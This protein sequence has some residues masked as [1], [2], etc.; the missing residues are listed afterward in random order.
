MGSDPTL[1]PARAARQRWALLERVSK[2][3]TILSI[4]L[5]ATI[6]LAVAPEAGL[7]VRLLAGGAFLAAWIWC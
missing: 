2:V 5:V 1:L 7:P 4:L 3:A 6:Q